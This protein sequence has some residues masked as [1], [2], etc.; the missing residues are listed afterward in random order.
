MQSALSISSRILVSST[1]FLTIILEKFWWRNISKSITLF[2]ENDSTFIQN[3]TFIWNFFWIDTFITVKQLNASK[4]LLCQSVNA[5]RLNS[6]DTAE[7]RGLNQWVCTLNLFR[8]WILG[9]AFQH[10][11]SKFRIDVRFQIYTI[12]R[13]S[14]H[15]R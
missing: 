13:W 9:L 8:I 12:D 4:G 3:L 2:F 11:Y 6:R 14:C 10:D 15:R 7:R 5:Y 1:F